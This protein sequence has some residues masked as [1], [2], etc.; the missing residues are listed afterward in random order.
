MKGMIKFWFMKSDDLATIDDDIMHTDP[1]FNL[2]SESEPKA[3]KRY[4]YQHEATDDPRDDL[5]YYCW[6]VR[7]APREECGW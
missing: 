4:M 1:Y 5:P 6:Y 3:K 7:K 2:E